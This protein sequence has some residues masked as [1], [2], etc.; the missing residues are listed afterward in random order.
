MTLAMGRPTGPAGPHPTGPAGPHPG[1][2]THPQPSGPSGPSGP[3]QPTPDPSD[4]AAALAALVA[5]VEAQLSVPLATLSAA[6]QDGVP[7]MAGVHLNAAAQHLSLALIRLARVD[8]PARQDHSGSPAV[9]A[10]GG[11]GP[12]G[13]RLRLIRRCTGKTLADGWRA[14]CGRTDVHGL[15]PI[16]AVPVLGVG[17]LYDALPSQQVG[18]AEYRSTA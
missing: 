3:P 12:T 10:T 11:P 2:P 4:H 8:L 9:A 14:R 6:V 7:G 17:P 18:V 5:D 16:G 13:E 1:G 15:H